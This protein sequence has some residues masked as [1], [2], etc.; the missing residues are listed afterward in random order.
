MNQNVN[1]PP[2]AKIAIVI[3]EE[4]IHKKLSQDMFRHVL[5]FVTDDKSKNAARAVNRH[6]KKT[7]V[8]IDNEKIAALKDF[9]KFLSQNLKLNAMRDVL[10]LSEMNEEKNSNDNNKNFVMISKNRFV[11]ILQ[12]LTT[13]EVCEIQSL[14]EKNEI[15][16]PSLM[17]IFELA[18]IYTKLSESLRSRRFTILQSEDK[19]FLGY[20]YDQDELNN[21]LFELVQKTLMMR[22]EEAFDKVMAVAYDTIIK[23][24]LFPRVISLLEE[25]GYYKKAEAISAKLKEGGKQQ[26]PV[27][28]QFKPDL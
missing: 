8:D 4:M 13:K 10:W 21:N 17:N 2:R 6:W 3:E 14:Y 19:F 5:S 23:A 11:N 18:K 9:G 7:L 28:L 24:K 20:E 1:P 26:M 25:K 16:D 12:K 27:L 22:D 15:Y